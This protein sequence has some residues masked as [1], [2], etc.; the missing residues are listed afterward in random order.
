MIKHN[1]TPE[2]LDE[3]VQSSSLLLVDFWAEWCVP[4]KQFAS[5]YEEIAAEYPDVIFA[6]V[7][8]AKEAELAETFEIRSIPHLLIFK[9]GMIIYSESG[10]MPKSRLQ[11]L[12]SQAQAVDVK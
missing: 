8:I 2:Q 11:T 9:Q 6:K 5:V 12:V 10:S 4:C 7:D 1:V 3:L